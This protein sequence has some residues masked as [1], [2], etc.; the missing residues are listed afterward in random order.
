M[1]YSGTPIKIY[2]HHQRIKLDK[3]ISYEPKIPAENSNGNDNGIDDENEGDNELDSLR[4]LPQ[5][6]T[7]GS[8]VVQIRNCRILLGQY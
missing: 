6:N 3:K 1:C 4:E 8:F 2:S 7:R 5:Q